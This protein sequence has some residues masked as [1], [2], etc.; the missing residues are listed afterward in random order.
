MMRFAEI[1]FQIDPF[2]LRRNLEFFV[3]PD[4]CEIGSDENLRHIPVPKFVS[5]GR[6]VWIWLLVKLFVWALEEEVQIRC[7]PPCSNFR[8]IPRIRLP[9]G[10]CVHI[11][12]QRISPE[13]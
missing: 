6:P 1:N 9:M 8:T 2:A 11:G 10:I 13:H 7:R 5:L 12:R 4:V 3:M